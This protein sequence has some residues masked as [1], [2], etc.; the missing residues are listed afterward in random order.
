M[1][2]CEKQKREELFHR[3]HEAVPEVDMKLLRE[4]VMRVREKGFAGRDGEWDRHCACIAAPIFDQNG[5]LQGCL[6]ISVPD[7]RLPEDDSDYVRLI[8]EGAKEI[9]LHMGWYQ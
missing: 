9:S 7:F 8:L 1:A 2:F 4:K 3:I 5:M 6:G